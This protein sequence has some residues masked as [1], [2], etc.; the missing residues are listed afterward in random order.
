MTATFVANNLPANRP[1]GRDR[2]DRPLLE[3]VNDR[4]DGCGYGSAGGTSASAFARAR[5]MTDGRASKS[6]TTSSAA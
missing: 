6:I 1:R 4:L 5:S 2:A 3:R